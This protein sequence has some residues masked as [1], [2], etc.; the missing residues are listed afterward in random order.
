MDSFVLCCGLSFDYMCSRYSVDYFT[1]KLW[2]QT[3]VLT[4]TMPCVW[5]LPSMEA[6]RHCIFELCCASEISD[7]VTVTVPFFRYVGKFISRKERLHER[8]HHQRFTNVYIKNFGEDFTDDQLVEVFSKYGKV[9]SARVM[10]DHNTGK[11]RGFGF[12]SYEDHEVASQVCAYNTCLLVHT[13][14][15]WASEKLAL[16]LDSFVVYRSFA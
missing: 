13:P 11:G 12:V 7:R 16:H 3:Q 5:A 14:S 6:C 4:C 1:Y 2:P 10:L 9:V 15:N 8:G